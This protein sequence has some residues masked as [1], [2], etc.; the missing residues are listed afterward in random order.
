MEKL[1]YTQDSIYFRALTK[2]EDT[3]PMNWADFDTRNKYP[4]M[5]Q[6]YYEIVI[7]R[8]AD[9]IPMLIQFFLLKESAQVLCE[10]M[11]GLINGVDLDKALCENSDAGCR[12][13]NLQSRIEHLSLAQRSSA[14]S[15]EELGAKTSVCRVLILKLFYVSYTQGDA[16]FICERTRCTA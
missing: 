1:V 3:D 11:L 16:L 7:Q 10:E 4:E 6:A 14:I 12:R 5:L 15:S 2:M 13:N 9:Q 8:L